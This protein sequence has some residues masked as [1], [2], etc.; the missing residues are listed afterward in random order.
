[1]LGGFRVLINERAVPQTAWRLGK[2]RSLIQLLC[3]TP[4]HRLHREQIMDLFWPDLA[5]KAAAGNFYQ[6]VHAARRALGAQDATLDQSAPIVHLRQQVVVLEP[7]GHLWI[8][9]DA[10]TQAAA[11]ARQ[12][13]DPAICRAAIEHYRGD[14][15]PEYPYDEWLVERRHALR[16]MLVTL[17]FHEARLHE[18]QADD[19]AARA[20]LRQ[21]IE[22]E[23]T[24]EQAHAD[25]MR[26]LARAGQP[27]LALDQYRQLRETLDRE[28]GEEP[29][30]A[31]T[32]RS[33]EI[34]S[35]V[36][37]SNAGNQAKARGNL[38]EPLTSFVGRRRELTSV[39]SVVRQH[40]IVTLTGAGGCGKTRLALSA[41]DALAAAFPDGVWLLELAALAEPALV[42][43]TAA[44][45]LGV[46]E[47][48]ERSLEATLIDAL[49]GRS[50]LIVLDNCEHLL[51][52][53]ASFCTAIL[54]ACPRIHILATSRERLHV[55][56]EQAWRVPSLS[57]PEAEA[58]SP[59]QLEQSEAI[60]L[61]VE[62]AHLAQ[63]GFAVNAETASDV[64][65]IC[66][67]LDGIPLAIELAAARVDVMDV[68]Q[69]AR[70][71]DD[72]LRLLT[73]GNR[74]GSRRHQTLRAALDWGYGLLT[75]AQQS[76]LNR[77]SVFAGSWTL[78][79]AEA[80]L[81]GDGLASADVQERVLQLAERSLVQIEQAGTETRYRLLEVV[82]QYASERLADSMR[83]HP[84]A[85]DT[86]RQRHAAY[87]ARL[88]ESIE[89]ILRGPEQ[90]TGLNRLDVEIENLRAALTWADE[91]RD[92]TLGLQLC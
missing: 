43:K 17:L 64:A 32:R 41:A 66:R 63:P 37:T 54:E 84:G 45:A 39:L 36:P 79:A 20:A 35:A 4:G 72:A 9:V 1:L 67:R 87:Y 2:A 38:K 7:P 77:L 69:I 81:S 90:A 74:S 26:L 3:L 86:V 80:T 50:L 82:R 91:A 48:P 31:I 22:H 75:D 21:I 68:G 57:L 70:R 46:T 14:L 59:E 15:L 52:A 60:Q 10:F 8:D 89:E 16:D 34:A 56:G 40:R 28:L 24:N 85:G 76:T 62:R 11:S 61:F 27:A 92:A 19:S 88:A 44:T 5:P 71:L 30:E 83:Q 55:A 73:E 12:S 29:G 53:C 13:S 33:K 23:P 78:A 58:S 49:Q 25:L 42:L 65:A 47:Q 6:V 18:Q 51:D